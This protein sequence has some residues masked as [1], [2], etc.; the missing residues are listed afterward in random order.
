MYKP[1]L[2]AYKYNSEWNMT[3]LYLSLIHISLDAETERV[4]E[5][6]REGRVKEKEKKKK[7][8]KKET[9]GEERDITH[10]CTLSIYACE[11]NL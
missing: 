8:R 5:W 9:V 7:T 10:V 6:V 11:C 3:I 2:K 1:L 4:N